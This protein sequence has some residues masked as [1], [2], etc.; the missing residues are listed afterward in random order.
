MSSYVLS[1]PPKSCPVP[2]ADLDGVD[3]WQA[4]LGAAAAPPRTGLV[5]NI[6]YDVGTGLVSGAIRVGDLKLIVNT[7]N[8]AVYPVPKTDAP[9]VRGGWQ[10][11]CQQ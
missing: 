7:V 2:Q 10:R 9:K 8:E 5:Y 6:D 3:H 1:C 4:L 11:C